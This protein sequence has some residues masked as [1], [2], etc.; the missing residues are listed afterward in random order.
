M[1]TTFQ[2]LTAIQANTRWNKKMNQTWFLGILILLA[3]NG[4]EGDEISAGALK[5][6]LQA[7]SGWGGDLVKWIEKVDAAL[8]TQNTKI[9]DHASKLTDH[10][11]KITTLQ[12][13][14]VRFGMFVSIL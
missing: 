12:N 11:S 8:K 2:L 13:A 4:I 3:I 10:A 7:D 14:M 6:I 5:K 9:T 1:G